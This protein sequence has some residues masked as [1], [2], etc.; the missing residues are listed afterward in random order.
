MRDYRKELFQINLLNA[1]YNSVI[2][3]IFLSIVK[4]K[5]PIKEVRIKRRTELWVANDILK[6]IKERDKAFHDFKK[7]KTDETFSILKT[8]QTKYKIL[9]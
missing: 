2:T 3:S 9:F 7:H 5:A 8:F 6:S 1:D 4:N